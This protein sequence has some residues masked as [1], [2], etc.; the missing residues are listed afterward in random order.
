VQ[1]EFVFTFKK[2]TDFQDDGLS[3]RRQWADGG[4]GW[5]PVQELALSKTHK[6]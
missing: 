5:Q 6:L 4:F 2:I 1:T 3:R